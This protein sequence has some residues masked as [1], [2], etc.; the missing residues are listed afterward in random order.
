MTRTTPRFFVARY[1]S[2]KAGK[3]QALGQ[4]CL[5]IASFLGSGDN[6]Q[7]KGQS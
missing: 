1:T 5:L 4:S 2:V 6:K 7:D 3:N